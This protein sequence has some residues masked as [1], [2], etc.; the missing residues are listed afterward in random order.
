MARSDRVAPNHVARRL[1]PDERPRGH[2]PCM[3]LDYWQKKR[4]ATPYPAW[5]DVSLMDLWQFADSMTVKDVIDGGRDFR[6]RYW[7]SRL[8]AYIGVEGTGR[9]H[10]EMFGADDEGH[11]F[12][13]R[14]VV[15]GGHGVLSYRRF[16][17]IPGRDHVTCE[18]L[19]LPLGPEGGAV[20]HVLSVFDF[21]VDVLD[22]LGPVTTDPAGGTQAT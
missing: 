1:R 9:T 2:G 10:S 14:R 7:G 20:M 5:R 15:E 8:T 16:T 21:T 11:F 19:H 6:N 22:I 12:T 13:Y 18:G 4:G 17:Y 3:L